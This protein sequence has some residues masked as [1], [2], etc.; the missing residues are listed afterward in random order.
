MVSASQ[1]VSATTSVTA[2][3]ATTAPAL[4]GPRPNPDR[5]W[6]EGLLP[7]L[8]SALA[9]LL[10]AS[11]VLARR[12]RAAGLPVRAWR[13]AA[14]VLLI[15]ILAGMAGACGGGGGST[16]TLTGGT[17]AGTFTITVTAACGNVSH[18]TTFSLRVSH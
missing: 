10:G 17:P 18:T 13:Y 3:V 4:A 6:P 15:F 2:S 5:R 7:V 14:A 11:L 1:G 9:A 8:L 16:S 12:W